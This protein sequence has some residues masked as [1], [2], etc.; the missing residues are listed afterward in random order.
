MLSRT[1]PNQVPQLNC[2]SIFL[3]LPYLFIFLI[4]LCLTS[5]SLNHSSPS[6]CP[7]EHAL[8]APFPRDYSRKDLVHASS[9]PQKHPVP[10]HPVSTPG[11]LL[12]P[13][14]HS[15]WTVIFVFVH[16]TLLIR[17]IGGFDS[18]S[19]WPLFFSF[20]FAHP[21]ISRLLR[22]S[23]QTTWMLARCWRARSPQVCFTHWAGA[24]P[25]YIRQLPQYGSC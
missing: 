13:R 2:T 4:R 21:H 15:L 9:Y 25:E 12:P 23:F 8:K 17:R 1:I 3:S 11:I 16:H 14:P 24:S 6:S 22:F 20:H 18:V 10:S 19:V 7:L 5:E